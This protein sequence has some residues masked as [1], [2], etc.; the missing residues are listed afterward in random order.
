MHIVDIV[1]IKLTDFGS[2]GNVGHTYGNNVGGAKVTIQQ[3]PQNKLTNFY[4]GTTH[5]C[6]INA[7]KNLQISNDEL[8]GQQHSQHLSQNTHK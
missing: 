7:P 3:K 8:H 2:V 1:I 5:P 4:Y 6:T